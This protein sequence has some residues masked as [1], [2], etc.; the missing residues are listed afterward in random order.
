[1]T[2]DG[3]G[4]GTCEGTSVQLPVDEFE[5]QSEIPLKVDPASERV[6]SVEVWLGCPET[7]CEDG[8]D[9]TV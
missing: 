4:C 6:E 2:I 3:L 1:M 8:W 7:G 5:E 9:P